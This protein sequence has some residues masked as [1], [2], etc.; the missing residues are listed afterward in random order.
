[1][2]DH[3][4]RQSRVL[5]RPVTP[6]AAGSV[7]ALREGRQGLR[8]TLEETGT[9]LAQP[10]QTWRSSATPPAARG[11]AADV[12]SCYRHAGLVPAF[13]SLQLIAEATTPNG[14][15]IRF[16]SRFFLCR[17]PLTKQVMAGDG[18]LL[19]VAWRPLGKLSHL[20][21]ADVTEAVLHE[22]SQQFRKSGPGEI[23]RITYSNSGLRVE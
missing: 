10:G 15:P 3:T 19:A 20:P 13:A 21:M 6:R 16:H 22:A 5:A 8:E 4:T 17:S 18:E 9:L 12:W 11:Q 7:V 2:P 14:L 23:R 1:M